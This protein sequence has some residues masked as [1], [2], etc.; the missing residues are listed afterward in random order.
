[1]KLSTPVGQVLRGLRYDPHAS[2][3]WC[4]VPLAGIYWSDELPFRELNEKG[5]RDDMATILKVFA[6]R[7][8]YWEAGTMSTDDATVWNVA[9]AEFPKWPIFRRLD[10]SDEDLAAH[11]AVTDAVAN[12]IAS[13]GEEAD[14]LEIEEQDGQLRVSATFELNKPPKK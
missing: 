9:E 14:E 1:M 6:I 7:M 8:R 10:I 4:A 5:T 12:E 2:R 11:R 3:M 13:L